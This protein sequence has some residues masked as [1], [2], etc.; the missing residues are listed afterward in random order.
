MGAAEHADQTDRQ[1]EVAA[2]EALIRSYYR[3]LERGEALPPYYATDDEAG[4]L[5]PVVKIGS[6]AGEEFTGSQ[7]VAP[8][9][10]HVT[11][12]LVRNHLESRRLL[13]R[14]ADDVAW[15][16][17]L[18]WWSGE[19]AGQPF[20]SLTRWTG[21]CLRLATGWRFVQVHVSEGMEQDTER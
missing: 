5:G 12:T 20:A 19:S 21:V 17:D 9:V 15:F 3:A 8:A 14:R 2:V 16:S 10:Q 4:P 1:A 6:D 11:A 18:V 7:A 13:V